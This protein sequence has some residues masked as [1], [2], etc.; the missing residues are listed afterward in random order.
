[1]VR[2]LA[3]V[4]GT[5]LPVALAL[6]LWTSAPGKVG[7]AIDAEIKA[8]RRAFDLPLLTDFAWT[9]AHVFRGRTPRHE[10]CSVLDISGIHCWWIAPETVERGTVFLV[11]R[12][13]REIVHHETVWIDSSYAYF[14]HSPNELYPTDARFKIKWDPS[15]T[16]FYHA[17]NTELSVGPPWLARAIAL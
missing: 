4:I 7:R 15:V 3:I 9:T 6:F 5:T 16:W 1:M 11:F 13:G 14:W 8:A 12:N 10:V 17:P 2:K